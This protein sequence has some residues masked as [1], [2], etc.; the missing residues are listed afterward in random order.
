[1]H[2]GKNLS[3]PGEVEQDALSFISAL[4][5]YLVYSLL[6]VIFFTFHFLAFL[7]FETLPKYSTEVLYIVPNRKKAVMCLPEKMR[8]KYS[9]FK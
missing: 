1:M 9:S 2:T 3:H 7:L 5:K 4:N 6:S 8:V